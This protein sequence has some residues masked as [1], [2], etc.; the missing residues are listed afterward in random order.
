M[1]R[2]ATLDD[3]EFLIALCR[4]F[5]IETGSNEYY[6]F[7]P[8]SVELTLKNLILSKYVITDGK[9]GMFAFNIYPA[10]Y[11]YK[12]NILNEVFWYVR[13]K[14]I[15]RTKRGLI[16]L[17]LLKRIDEEAKLN[18]VRH[19]CINNLMKYKYKKTEKLFYQIGYTHRENKY[20]KEV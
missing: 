15:S 14:K 13:K 1:I 9:H 6:N 17:K 7:D 16:A 11:D 8:K 2:Y 4:E 10:F 5:Y 18:N 20:M 3:I 12:S 19:V